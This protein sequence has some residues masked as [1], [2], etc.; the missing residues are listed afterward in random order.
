MEDDL[1]TSR[2]K[3]PFLSGCFD[4]LFTYGNKFLA[5]LHQKN[6]T[7]QKAETEAWFKDVE[8]QIEVHASEI[9]LQLQESLAS[10]Y[11]AVSYT[12]LTLPTIYS[13]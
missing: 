6:Q 2:A 9:E 5:R 12:H 8:R 7:Q 1:Q 4:T 10:T 13:V 3:Y 11:N